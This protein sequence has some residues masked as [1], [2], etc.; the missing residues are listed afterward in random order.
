MQ[1]IKL[2]MNMRVGLYTVHWYHEFFPVS[3]YIISNILQ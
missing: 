1:A 3:F 2:Q